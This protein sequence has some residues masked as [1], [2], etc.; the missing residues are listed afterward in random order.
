MNGGEKAASEY[1]ES[2]NHSK[3]DDDEEDRKGSK[4]KDKRVS[5]E[6]K[7]SAVKGEEPSPE[8]SVDDNESAEDD[9]F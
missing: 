2:D 8:P 7:E 9:I 4:E 1:N 6:K 3:F 5:V